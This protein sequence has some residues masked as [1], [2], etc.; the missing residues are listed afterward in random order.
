MVTEKQ[1]RAW[2]VK[3]KKRLLYEF[4]LEDWCIQW[5]FENGSK[6]KGT[7]QASYKYKEAII[8]LFHK[9]HP[10]IHD[11]ERTVMHELSHIVCSGY[12]EL[13]DVILILLKKYP[14]KEAKKLL[15]LLY[16]Q[17]G[18]LIH[19]QVAVSIYKMSCRH[20]N[21]DFTIIKREDD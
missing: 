21:I 14:I 8:E 19:E 13:E 3:N 10:N 7:T 17:L 16:N 11:F 4:G 18:S 6:D 15:N 1:A 9:N 5:K 20:K 12:N 2:L